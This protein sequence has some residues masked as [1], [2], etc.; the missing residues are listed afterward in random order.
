MATSKAKRA[1]VRWGLVAFTLVSVLAATGFVFHWAKERAFSRECEQ[2]ILWVGAN[3]GKAGVYPRVALPS[4]LKSLSEDGTVDAVVLPDGRIVLLFKETLEWHHN[5]SGFV[6]T[7]APLKPGEIGRD[8]YGRP[9]IQVNGLDEHFV[10]ER[11]NDRLYRVRFD[12]G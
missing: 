10:E 6:F 1:W 3:Y 2:T 11:V 12:L 4:N 8:S 7:S 5:W 9:T